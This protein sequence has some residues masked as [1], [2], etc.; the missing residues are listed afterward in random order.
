MPPGKP[1]EEME[2]EQSNDVPMED[3]VDVFAISDTQL[4]VTNRLQGFTASQTNTAA[5][6]DLST[7]DNLKQKD[8][9]KV[10]EEVK[11]GEEEEEEETEKNSVPAGKPDEE[12]ECEQSNDVPM[13]DSVNVFAISDT[14][15]AITNRLQDCIASHANTA[16][17]GGGGGT[18]AQ[19]K[20][21]QNNENKEK[22]EDMEVDV[23][24][25][26]SSNESSVRT[27]GNAPAS[28]PPPQAS[29]ITPPTPSPSPPQPP[30]PSPPSSHNSRNSPQSTN[31]PSYKDSEINVYPIDDT[32]R[33]YLDSHKGWKLN[34]SI[35]FIR[36]DTQL[37]V[38][39]HHMTRAQPIPPAVNK[40]WIYNLMFNR[41]GT[42]S[43]E[44]STI[45]G[46]ELT[47]QEQDHLLPVVEITPYETSAEEDGNALDQCD[48]P[49]PS[50][51][52]DSVDKVTSQASNLS[53]TRT[54]SSP[55]RC[56]HQCE[57]SSENETER[58]QGPSAFVVVEESQD[59]VSGEH[60]RTYA[61]T[62]T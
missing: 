3:S 20:Q 28:L 31:R 36:L 7:S 16:A 60:T 56:L 38:T 40:A 55:V 33:N 39:A 6:S 54:Q 14:Q 10:A 37:V 51:A 50:V 57:S 29:L 11:K 49:K 17:D 21:T 61:H 58:A 26:G 27:L 52:S 2:C 9:E 15:L 5:V 43:F 47:S 1:A 13:E 48:V 32:Q 4:A 41:N 25:D 19:D 8:R 30:S 12:M 34:P 46:I 42:Y 23:S 35:G 22:D 44:V 18:S 45:K 53:E 62:H 24:K 59:L